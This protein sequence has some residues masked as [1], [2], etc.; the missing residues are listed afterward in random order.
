VFTSSIQHARRAAND[1]VKL[2]GAGV[3]IGALAGVAVFF[4][5]L[6]AFIWAT[7]K[8]GAI[9]AGLGFGIFFLTLAA[10]IFLM[11]WLRRRSLSERNQ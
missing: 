5:T 7:D 3:L 6:A 11:V 1:T 8:Y 9:V 4:I 10:A 2:A